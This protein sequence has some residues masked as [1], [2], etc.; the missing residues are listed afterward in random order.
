[1]GLYY[2]FIP[3]MVIGIIGMVWS[4]YALYK[5]AKKNDWVIG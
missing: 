2:V 4:G 1:M 5:S 3:L